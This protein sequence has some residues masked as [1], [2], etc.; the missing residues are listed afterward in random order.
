M[1]EQ[2]HLDNVQLNSHN[3][4]SDEKNVIRKKMQIDFSLVKYSRTITK[5]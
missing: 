5:T 4:D 2:T 3:G 1:I